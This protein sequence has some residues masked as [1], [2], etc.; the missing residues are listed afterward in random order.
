MLRCST[1]FVKPPPVR[2][3]SGAHQRR[4]PLRQPAAHADSHEVK[5]IIVASGAAF[6]GGMGFAALSLPQAATAVPLAV[7]LVGGVYALR[8][9]L[10]PPQ[11]SASLDASLAQAMPAWNEGRRAALEGMVASLAGPAYAAHAVRCSALAAML[12]EQLALNAEET[13]H[14]TLAAAVHV[15]PIAYPPV[16]DFAL[17]G[18]AFRAFS[19]EAAQSVLARTASPQVARI[20]AEVRERWDGSGLPARL[21]RESISMGGRVVAAACAFDH[22][23]LAGL[24]AGL[25][26]IRQ[27]SGS[28]YD[29]VV[30]A[31]ILHLF[32]QP[33]QQRVAA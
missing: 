3:R 12:A 1:E 19:L 5:A 17:E 14:V 21:S 11:P 7:A 28:A 10:T 2:R 26:V 22:A 29:P 6:A 15:L 31:E 9:R 27:G 25:E 30:A 8:G 23:S 13:S 33:W 24:E 4:L 16:E 32:R 18:C 20:S